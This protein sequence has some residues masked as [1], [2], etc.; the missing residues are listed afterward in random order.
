M[1]SNEQAASFY[2]GWDIEKLVDHQQVPVTLGAVGT[3][4]LVANLLPFNFS[5]PPKVVALLSYDG[6]TTWYLPGGHLGTLVIGLLQIT[7]AEI[8]LK[9]WNTGGA[10]IVKY[11]IFSSG[12]L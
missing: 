5:N 8:R 2:S 10:V 3:T 12:I 6:G 11:W 1:L 9:S 7:T 4:V